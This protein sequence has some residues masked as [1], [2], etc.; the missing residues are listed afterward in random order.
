MSKNQ[1]NVTTSSCLVNPFCDPILGLL[2]AVAAFGAVL[3]I[4]LIIIFILDKRLQRPIYIGIPLLALPDMLFL[5]AK[6][7]T[8]AFSDFFRQK[9]TSSQDFV[10]IQTVNCIMVSSYFS[11]ASHVVL[12]SVQQYI[13]IA[14]PLKSGVWF[15][16]TKVIVTSAI[17]WS[18][19]VVFGITYVY[20]VVIN[21]VN[22]RMLAS[23]FNIV[24]T[25]IIT[26][27]PVLILVVLHF[28]KKRV[29]MSSMVTRPQRSVRKMARVVSFV[30]AGYLIT[31]T[32]V[33]IKDIIEV[34]FG[35]LKETWFVI[36]YE[37]ST[38]LLYLNYSVNP[39]IYFFSTP[40]FRR[41]LC[42]WR[43]KRSLY[44]SNNTSMAT[45]QTS[46]ISSFQERL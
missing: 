4:L 39:F 32:P 8:I 30:I 24:L 16:N 20:I 35:Y 21:K 19:C 26:I 2:G 28:L 38:I 10:L 42:C 17:T 31:T 44:G 9:E 14:Y 41:A 6:L 46:Q 43:N 25:F 12:L 5:L 40:Q 13:Y 1:T 15:K 34:T 45:S 3:N 27:L 29:L 37:V 18:V 7:S 23:K 22:N 33:N 11:S 36:F